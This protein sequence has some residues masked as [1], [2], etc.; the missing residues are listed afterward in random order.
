VIRAR[1]SRHARRPGE[2]APLRVIVVDDHAALSRGHRPGVA[3]GVDEAAARLALSG[4]IAKL[5][6]DTLPEAL[7]AARQLRLVR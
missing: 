6:A 2:S 3:L 1:P 7:E 4:A 5:G